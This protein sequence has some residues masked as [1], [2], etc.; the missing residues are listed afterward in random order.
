MTCFLPEMR[1]SKK[2]FF[3]FETNRGIRLQNKTKAI[4]VENIIFIVTVFG[5]L[6]LNA[7]K[8]LAL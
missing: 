3:V 7:V 4:N 6:G 1:G 5:L 8:I 2:I